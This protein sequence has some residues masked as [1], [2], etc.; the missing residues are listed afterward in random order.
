MF[1]THRLK[2]GCYRQ[3]LECHCLDSHCILL[4]EHK[5]DFCPRYIWLRFWHPD[6]EHLLAE[7]D[8]HFLCLVV[9]DYYEM[10]Q[11]LTSPSVLEVF[12]VVKSSFAERERESYKIS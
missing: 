10:P 8:F 5:I 12:E 7:L 2:L 11:F 4:L 3:Q 9:H 6:G 1:G